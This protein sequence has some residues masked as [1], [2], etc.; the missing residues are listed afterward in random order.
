MYKL[1]GRNADPKQCSY[2][3]SYSFE[4]LSEMESGESQEYEEIAHDECFNSIKYFR[5]D[6]LCIIKENKEVDGK[7]GEKGL[8][9]K[10]LK[11]QTTKVEK[12]EASH[13]NKDI[14]F[15]KLTVEEMDNF[16][17]HQNDTPGDKKFT[18]ENSTLN[19]SNNWNLSQ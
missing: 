2:R 7:K 11:D 17:F 6:L 15:N 10:M 13:V 5:H 8:I 18:L 1:K 16:N 3:L 9:E 12:S 14:H 4:K 19:K